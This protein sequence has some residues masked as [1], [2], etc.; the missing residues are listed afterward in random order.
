MRIAGAVLAA[1]AGTRYGMPK[2]LARAADGTPW[3]DRAV[4][5]LTSGGV[6]GGVLVALG[7]ERDSAALLLPAGATRVDV[8]DWA[9]GIAAT[10]QA[11]LSAVADTAADALLV[12]P[13]DTPGMPAS[14]VQR[15]LTH[16]ASPAALVRATYGGRPGHPVL[17]GRSHWGEVAAS[18]SGDRGA[19]PYLSAQG[20]REVECGD[21]WN[22]A[23]VDSPA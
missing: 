5:A 2:A 8:P 14:A 7:A 21:L 6:D 3:M 9:S 22:G 1:G 18:V 4:A 11:V 15:I 19:G 20:A 13:V 12:V 17:L 10:L 23:D 16:A